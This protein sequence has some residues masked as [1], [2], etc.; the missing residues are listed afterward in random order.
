MRILF[1]CSTFLLTCSPLFAQLAPSQSQPRNATVRSPL[2]QFGPYTY[3][4]KPAGDAF[5][6]LN[7]RR[8]PPT[9][10]AT[11]LRRGDRLAIIGDSITEQ[12]MYSRMIETYLTVCAPQ[13]EIETRQYG[14]SG[15]KAAQFLQRMDQDCLRFQPTV[16]TLSYGMNDA[17]Y[18]P[19]DFHTGRWYS[20]HYSA[21]VERFQHSGARVVVGSPGCSGKIASWV[22]SRAGTLDEHNQNLCVLRDIAI[23][24]SLD[25]KVGFADVFWPMYQAQVKF[26]AKFTTATKPYRVAGEDGIHP[27]WAGH[28]LMAYAF[29]KALGL[30]GNLACIEIDLVNR[31][32]E[33]SEGHSL[34]ASAEHWW[35]IESERYPFCADGKIDDENSIRSGMQLVP[36]NENLNRWM[37]VVVGLDASKATIRWGDGKRTYTADQ[38]KAGVNL[39]DDF[40]VNPFSSAFEQVDRAVAAKQ[41]YETKQIQQ[42][43]HGEQGKRDIE[44]A[45]KE[46]EAVRQSLVDAMGAA[47]KPVRH[48]IEIRIVK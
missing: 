12:K 19:F 8:A 29:L 22:A 10:E 46:T 42:V 16:A 20:D 9:P 3:E 30:D 18:R 26:D 36:F 15:E 39:A 23:Q 2:P 40:Q 45:V 13:L 44:R 28:T 21:I 35:E 47:R 6:K 7:P 4:T 43:F 24:I 17:R 48:R 38:L 41:A 11:L 34:V 37:L 32:I 27:G 33:L 1:I 31:D 5:K 14:W 25:R